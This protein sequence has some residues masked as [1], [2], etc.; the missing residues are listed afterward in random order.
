[1][2]ERVVRTLS[3]PAQDLAFDPS[4]ERLL[5]AHR[6][7]ADVYDVAS[8]ESIVTLGGHNGPVFSVAYNRNGSRI[9]TGSLDATVRLWDADSGEQELVLRGHTEGVRSVA[10]SPDDSML[11]SMSANG[12]VRVWALDLDDLMR[13][14]REELTRDLTDDECRQYLHATSC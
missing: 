8:G 10:F 11:A 14:A 1:E 12:A 7:D 9:A 6:E 5:V 13:I 4:G 3:V 2:E